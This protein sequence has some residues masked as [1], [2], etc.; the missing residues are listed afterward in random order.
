MSETPRTVRVRIA[1]AVTEIGHWNA[2]GFYDWDDAE[3]VDE[4]GGPLA[5]LAT[6][7]H[8]IEA[9]IPLPQPLTIQGSVVE[10]PD[11]S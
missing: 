4:V 2:S 10:T 3:A 1:V 9:D 11:A 5:G 8:F 7:V 6:T